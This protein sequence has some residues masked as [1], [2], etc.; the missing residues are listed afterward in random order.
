MSTNYE[1]RIIQ[2]EADL[3][4]SFN[5]LHE[6]LGRYLNLYPFISFEKEN[7]IDVNKFINGMHALNQSFDALYQALKLHAEILGAEITIE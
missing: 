2:N 3:F 4:Q 1:N 7:N 6:L 5:N